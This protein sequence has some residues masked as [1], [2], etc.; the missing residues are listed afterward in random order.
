MAT[1]LPHHAKASKKNRK[2]N[3]NRVRCALYKAQ[4][5]RFKNKVRRIA[6]CNG[7]A[8]LK[9]YLDAVRNKEYEKQ[10]G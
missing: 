4:N 3:R 9:A 10:V 8:F 2:W 1:N 6:R 7:E 5:R